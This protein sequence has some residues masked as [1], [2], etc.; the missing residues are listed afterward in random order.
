MSPVPFAFRTNVL[1]GI[2]L[3]IVCQ[4]LTGTALAASPEPTKSM[5]SARTDP[6]QS[7][8]ERLMAVARETHQGTGTGVRHLSIENRPA[9]GDEDASLLLV[10]VASFECP[11]CRRHWLDTMPALRQNYIETGKLHYV[12]ID[13]VIDPR[14]RHAQAAAE[15]AHCANEQGQYPEFRD[16][17]YRNH[18]AI[19][20]EFLEAHAQAVGIDLPEFRRCMA[21]GIYRTQVERDTELG[22]RLRVRG[23]PSFFWARAEPGRTDVRLVRRTS[24]ARPM[25]HFAEQ[26][27]ALYEQNPAVTGKTV[28]A[29]R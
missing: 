12:F 20:A 14:H 23:T 10:E 1:A 16:R 7:E 13:V 19:A 25:E 15:A 11:Y 28:E 8:F 9:I 29:D 24:G 26:F 22:R 4:V 5:L 21:S 6:P 2:V 17:M 27:D 18:K 3:A